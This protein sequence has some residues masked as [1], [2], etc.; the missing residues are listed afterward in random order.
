MLTAYSDST[1]AGQARVAELATVGIVNLAR[2]SMHAHD[3][4]TQHPGVQ[5]DHAGITGRCRM[6]HCIGDGSTLLH[7]QMRSRAT[8]FCVC[9]QTGLQKKWNHGSSVL[10]LYSLTAKQT[11]RRWRITITDEKN[12]QA[13]TSLCIPCRVP[14]Q[15]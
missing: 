15:N 3:F 13:G 1:S 14:E 4:C 2:A 12:V 8:S 7:A 10:S 5:A 11:V 6:L 9:M